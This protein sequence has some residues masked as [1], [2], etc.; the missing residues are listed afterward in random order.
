MRRRRSEI[1]GKGYEE[2]TRLI[3]ENTYG[4]CKQIK[5][6]IP[7]MASCEGIKMSWQCSVDEYPTEVIIKMSDGKWVTYQM[8]VEQ[9]GFQ[10]ETKYLRYEAL[11]NELDETLDERRRISVAGR[12]VIPDQGRLEEW[13]RLTRKAEA[14]REEMRKLRYGEAV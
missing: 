6:Q 7:V 13:N 9:P 11:S 12:G 10:G 4:G 8:K 3:E 1:F 14:I 2:L 5:R